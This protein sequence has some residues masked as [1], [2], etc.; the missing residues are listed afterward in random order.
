MQKKIILSADS[1]CDIGPELQR[2]YDVKF[3][4]YHI[5]VGEK[6]YIDKLEITKEELF[7]AWRKKGILPKTAA[8]TPQDY[9]DFFKEWVAQGYEVVHINLGGGLSSSHQNCCAV[10]QELSGIYPVDSKSLSSGSGH[11]V[12]QAGRMIEEGKLS[13]QEIQAALN[14]MRPRVHASFVV[15]TLEFL[16]AGGR[17][18]ALAAFS[19][20]LLSLKPC[21]KVQ[22]EQGGSMTSGKKY[23][24]NMKKVL[25]EYVKDCLQG[26]KDLEL[27][28][29][30]ITHTGVEDGIVEMVRREIAKYASFAEV[31]ETE[32]SGT[33]AAHCGPGTLGI[34][35]MTKA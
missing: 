11:L 15:E 28:R 12:V 26:R 4:N 3:F 10:A 29:I 35:Y 8:I 13:A 23:R 31:T 16:R 7:D 1:T 30:F 6:T 14:D 21:I 19:A 18:S 22:T 32:A 34:L 27:E 20:N 33:I 2:R 25:P 17:C 9:A 24:G 5:Q